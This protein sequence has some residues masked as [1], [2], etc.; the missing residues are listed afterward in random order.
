MWR[1]GPFIIF[2]VER[3]L[4][5]STPYVGVV[6]PLKLPYHVVVEFLR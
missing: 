5:V 3:S 4:G 1:K 2:L 6:T